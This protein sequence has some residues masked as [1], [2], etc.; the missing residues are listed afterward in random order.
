MKECF[1]L[2][3][4]IT[5]TIASRLSEF[6]M[7]LVSACGIPFGFKYPYKSFT[8]MRCTASDWVNAHYFSHYGKFSVPAGANSWNFQTFCMK[9]LYA[10]FDPSDVVQDLIRRLQHAAV[11]GNPYAEEN[12]RFASKFISETLTRLDLDFAILG[13]RLPSRF[14]EQ[15]AAANLRKGA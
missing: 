7:D 9:C 6:N 2:L 10:S 4:D 15:A 3:A 13:V 14:I 11:Y 8:I 1:Y 12:A 5:Q